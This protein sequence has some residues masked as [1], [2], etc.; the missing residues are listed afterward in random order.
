MAR[1]MPNAPSVP[2]AP[3]P[4]RDFTDLLEDVVMSRRHRAE[5]RPG[6]F[7]ADR[8]GNGRRRRSGLPLAW[9]VLLT[10]VTLA[11]P[12]RSAAGPYRGY[13]IRFIGE[14]SPLRKSP[15]YAA[16]DNPGAPAMRNNLGLPLPRGTQASIY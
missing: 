16:P 4:F 5:R 13:E 12:A 11:G 9:L 2:M 6:E 1:T 15:N 14:A 8:S 7:M 10:L 3:H